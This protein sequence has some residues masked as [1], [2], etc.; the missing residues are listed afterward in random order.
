MLARINSKPV[1]IPINSAIPISFL[2][3]L[4]I[5][6]KSVWRNIFERGDK[7]QP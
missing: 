6:E 5:N 7:K 1:P 2:L 4:N 3:K